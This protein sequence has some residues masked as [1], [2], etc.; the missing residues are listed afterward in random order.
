[1]ERG[2][3]RAEAGGSRR[4]S[5]C[6]CVFSVVL[7]PCVRLAGVAFVCSVVFA[8][9]GISSPQLSLRAAPVARYAP[10]TP[11]FLSGPPIITQSPP[12]PQD[13]WYSFVASVAGEDDGSADRW[14]DP[15]L[16]PQAR[17][18]SA[19]ATQQQRRCSAAAALQQPLRAENVKFCL[20]W[21]RCFAGD[22][23]S[24]CS[25]CSG[26]ASREN[27]SGW[28]LSARSEHAREQKAPP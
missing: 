24:A 18:R 11:Q 8:R 12:H 16:R 6:C 26:A 2:F 22:G 4:V 27:A 21:R 13:L 7:Q 25:A 15:W 3:S 19:A 28:A 9:E 5:W 14:A 1:M 23:L 20:S 10:I 17:M